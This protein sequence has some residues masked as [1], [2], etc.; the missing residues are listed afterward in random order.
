MKQSMDAMQ[1]LQS[2]LNSI[3]PDKNK[4]DQEVLIKIDSII[5]RQ[6]VSSL[7]N[8]NRK[9]AIIK[10]DSWLRFLGFYGSIHL[11]SSAQRSTRARV[12][13]G[14]KPPTWMCNASIDL[15][16]E[17][18]TLSSQEFGLRLLP[19]EIKIQARISPTSPFMLA[20]LHGDV[21]LI[22]QHLKEKTG[23]V[24]DRTTCTGTTPLLVIH[25]M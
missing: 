18:A 5:E 12:M 20:C 6:S 10:A 15:A 21:K 23:S 11:I 16:A 13:I 1:T 3:Q 24:R 17:F 25:L 7:S 8:I 2:A 9:Q 22:E 4:D 14:F 19:G